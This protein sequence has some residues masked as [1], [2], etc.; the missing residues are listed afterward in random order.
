MAG[1]IMLKLFQMLTQPPLTV[2]ASFIGI[3]LVVVFFINSSDSGG[4]VIDTI[5][6]GG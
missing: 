6:A 3:I 5:A 1:S 2:I 4:L